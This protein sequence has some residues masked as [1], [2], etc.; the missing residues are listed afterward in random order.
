MKIE[1]K[2]SANGLGLIALSV[3]F[4]ILYGYF[5]TTAGKAMQANTTKPITN[6][7]TDINTVGALGG[8]HLLEAM[9]CSDEQGYYRVTLNTRL[10]RSTVIDNAISVPL[11]KVTQAVATEPIWLDGKYQDTTP[12]GDYRLQVKLQDTG[13]I[14]QVSDKPEMVFKGP[15]ELKIGQAPITKVRLVTG[16]D[17]TVDQVLI[18]MDTQ[19]KF[20]VSATPTGTIYIDILK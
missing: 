5:N 7:T 9:T 1:K 13:T 20:R 10:N 11:T 16:A 3:V 15:S 8:F 18:G 17:G 2:T 12:F 4:L 6:T 19:A 14:E